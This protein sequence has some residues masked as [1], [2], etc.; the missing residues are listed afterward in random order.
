V[1]FAILIGDQFPALQRD[2]VYATSTTPVIHT[3]PDGSSTIDRAANARQALELARFSRYT[4]WDFIDLVGLSSAFFI[5]FLGAFVWQ[6]DRRWA[7][8]D[9]IHARPVPTWQYVA[10]KYLGVVISWGVILVGLIL[11]GAGR[12]YQIAAQFGLPFAIREFLLPIFPT[13]GVS[14]LYGTAL[15]LALSLLLRHSVGALLIYFCCWAYVFIELGM[16]KQQT[17]IAQFLT[18]WFFRTPFLLEPETLA[19][20]Q[21]TQDIRWWNRV[22]YTLLTGALL[23][24]IVLLYQRLRAQGALT[25][26]AEPSETRSLPVWRRW[27]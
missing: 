19:I 25:R 16:L 27:W 14:L 6:R 17:G 13:I 4:A 1:L 22:L 3:S 9:S 10:G 18:Y 26:T 12:A 23:G 8:V 24:L 15:I 21:S 11:I 7:L 20:I 2:A 5:G